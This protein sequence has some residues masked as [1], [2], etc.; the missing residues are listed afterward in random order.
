MTNDTKS[1]NKVITVIDTV[2]HLLVVIYHAY[3]NSVASKNNDQTLWSSKFDISI[4]EEIKFLL[5]IRKLSKQNQDRDR[6]T[7][8]AELLKCLQNLP[9]SAPHLDTHLRTYIPDAMSELDLLYPK[10]SSNQGG[11]KIY[12]AATETKSFQWKLPHKLIAA[13]M[14]HVISHHS[15]TDDMIEDP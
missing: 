13:T 11:T 8:V 12:G 9:N 2:V 10:V 1:W 5:S 3:D 15:D 4:L 6:K 14:R 7:F